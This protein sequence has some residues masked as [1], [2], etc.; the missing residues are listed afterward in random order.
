MCV[1]PVRLT[2]ALFAI[3]LMA[4]L[5]CKDAIRGK[6]PADDAGGNFP[7]GAGGIAGSMA[8]AGNAAAGGADVFS[9]TPF[10]PS[11]AGRFKFGGSVAVSETGTLPSVVVGASLEFVTADGS[12][13]AYVFV[14]DAGTWSQQTKLVPGDG[15]ENQQ[16]GVSVA[17]DGD[18]ALV[19]ALL[20]DEAGLNAGAAY[21][22][23]RTGTTWTQQSKLMASDTTR[24]LGTAV[25]LSGDTAVLGAPR[26]SNNGSGSG[27][28]YV[29]VRQNGSWTQQGKL[30]A[31]DGAADDDLGR[32]VDIDGDTIVA[33]ARNTDLQGPDSG[34]AY[35]F[36]RNV[37]Q[38]SQ[39]AKLSR[40]GGAASIALG[41][42]VAIDGETIVT[43]AP[44]ESSAADSAGAAYVFE[45]AATDW[46]E[47]NR[48]VAVD[49]AMWDRLGTSASIRDNHI[50]LGSPGV[51]GADI[52]IGA[53]YVFARTNANAPWLQTAKLMPAVTV[54]E[55]FGTSV[56]LGLASAAGGAPDFDSDRGKIYIWSLD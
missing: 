15:A 44:E 48:L 54:V 47:T 31:A 51:D 14:Q 39:Q 9:G 19:G 43:T 16:F 38:W 27:A 6:P 3:A 2:F 22:F 42:A 12:G 4:P 20:D 36:V 13:A 25:A 45:R 5:S 50:L 23:V 28:V 53:V 37:D 29:F 55:Q 56:S 46:T 32:A 8:Q 35:V 41:S 17:L 10:S 18:T 7:G 30:L 33:G 21:V 26:D 24:Q 11:G 49:G 1:T 52:N 40:S 34:A